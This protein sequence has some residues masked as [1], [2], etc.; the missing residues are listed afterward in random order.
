MDVAIRELKAK[1][2]AYVQRAAAGERITV[3]DRGKPVAVLGPPIGQVDLDAAAAAGWLTPATS[4]GLGPVR[5]HR[6][7]RSVLEV[8]DE[9]RSE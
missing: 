6:A 3:T 2:S 5:R 7:V 4:E 1:L 9:D 8:L